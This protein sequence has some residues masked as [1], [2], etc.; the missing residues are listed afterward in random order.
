VPLAEQQQFIMVS[1]FEAA[2]DGDI[3][4]GQATVPLAEQQLSGFTTLPLVCD[5]EP[6]GAV[7]LKLV[8]PDAPSRS[9]TERDARWVPPASRGCS[10]TSNR[11]VG[12]EYDGL[13][14]GR[15]TRPPSANGSFVSRGNSPPPS[16]GGR[17]RSQQRRATSPGGVGG[18]CG[19]PCGSGSE[20]RSG[21]T[22]DNSAD[23]DLSRTHP[24]YKRPAD[25]P[26]LSRG[27]RRQGQGR[28]WVPPGGGPPCGGPSCGGSARNSLSRTNQNQSPLPSPKLSLTHSC[29][30]GYRPSGTGGCGRQPRSPHM[31]VSPTPL[32]LPQRGMCQ[33]PPAPRQ[34]SGQGFPCTS[35]PAS[36]KFKTASCGA[37]FAPPG[38]RSP[39]P[40]NQNS[41]ASRAAAVRGCSPGGSYPGPPFSPQLLPSQPPPQSPHNVGRFR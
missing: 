9:P 10:I 12:N 14:A 4:V 33:Q 17:K 36:P 32:P 41:L 40:V 8:F 18:P 3:F 38:A 37:P 2:Q 6:A 1:I 29:K 35:A 31:G 24:A 23:Q 30:G 28:S 34:H 21:H 13:R 39:F 20:P 26:N 7:T 15:G 25:S 19:G 5:G 11:N 16:N 22:M 27:L